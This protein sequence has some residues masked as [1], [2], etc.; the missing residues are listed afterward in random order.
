[1]SDDEDSLPEIGGEYTKLEVKKKSPSFTE[2]EKVLLLELV[3]SKRNIL[4]CKRSDPL[5]IIN[6]QAAWTDLE[7]SFNLSSDVIKR[8]A[9]QLKRAWENLKSRAKTEKAK[10][11][12]SAKKTGGGM[13]EHVLSKQSELI[14]AIVPSQM[15][16]LQNDFDSDSIEIES[17]K[18]ADRREKFPDSSSRKLST[19]SNDSATSTKLNKP[20]TVD[21]RSFVIQMEEEEHTI[22]MQILKQKQQYE[23]LKI[24]KLKREMELME[25]ESHKKLKLLDLQIAATNPVQH[26]VITA[27]DNEIEIA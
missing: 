22:N 3:S 11:V 1:M 27:P 18:P 5:T 17:D 21:K 8:T 4:E 19:S 2:S 26:F 20:L 12:R 23:E 14:C 6:K 15:T 7:G 10:A 9:A 16:S 25:L 24:K 13:A